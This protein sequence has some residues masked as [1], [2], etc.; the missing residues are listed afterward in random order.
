[1]KIEN[2][3]GAKNRKEVPKEIKNL[4]NEGKIS[5]VNLV[6]GLVIDQEK[7]LENV[8]IDMG[9]EKY[10]IKC[11]K[12][13]EDLNKK[14]YTK[15][16][17]TIGKSLLIELKENNDTRTFKLLVNHESDTVR[18]WATNIIGFDDEKTTSEKFECIKQF[19]S[20]SHFGVRENAWMAMRETISNNLEDSINILSK[21][22]KS[23]DLNLRRFASESTRPRGV[24]TKH[25]KELKENPELG[26]PILEP[27]KSDEE[28][29]VQNS[30]GNWLNDAS[31][32]KPQWVKDICEEWINESPTKETKQIIKRGLRTINKNEK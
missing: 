6:E 15:L 5:T 10:I 18:S 24:W 17:S 32:S 7:L 19:A 14:T 22:S 9:A 8:L 28:V 27:L 13:I 21:W 25:I 1:M 2:R 23:K 30:V 20:D 11:K 16:T 12:S 3:K 29:Y 31:K 4:L 26:L